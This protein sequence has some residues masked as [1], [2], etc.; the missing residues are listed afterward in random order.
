M[1][2]AYEIPDRGLWLLR[3][4]RLEALLDPLL[5]LLDACPPRDTLAPQAVVAAHPGMRQWLLAA[6]ARRRGP[7]GIVAN[8]DVVLPGAWLDG[9]VCDVLDAPADAAR[10]WRRDLLRWRVHD[11]LARL[12]D[13]RLD[14]GLH[15]PDAA[16]R[17]F[18]LADRLAR[19][20]VQYLVYRPDWLAAW[21]DGRRVREL[22][23]ADA[24][25]APLW[26]A[27]RAAI[28]SPH[29]GEQ[30]ERLLA[31]LARGR[32][33][34][35]D[36][37]LHLFGLT[38]LPPADLEVL[39]ALA[40][41][42]L[43]VLYV[44]DPCASEHWAGMPSERAALRA[45]AQADAG[46]QS[47]ETAFLQASH[48]LLGSFGRIGQH[49]LLLLEDGDV[50]VDERHG[51]DLPEA[52][53]APRDLLGW[54][55]EGIRRAEPALARPAP[56]P[57]GARADRS[58]RVHACHTRLRELEVLR[59]ALLMEL[60]ERPDL[61]PADIVVMAPDIGAYAPLLPAVFGAPGRRHGPLPWHLAD[62]PTA[63]G[64]PLRV[65]FERLLGI[66][67]SRLT[68]PEVA[69]LL[70]LPPIAGR[71]GLSTGD[72]DTLVRWLREARAAW[73]LDAAFRERFGVPTVAAQTF[74]WAM[75]RVLAGYAIGCDDE[76]PVVALCDGAAIAPLPGIAGAQAALAGAL[77]ALLV[78]LATWCEAAQ[79][80]RQASAWADWLDLRCDALLRPDP[81]DPGARDAERALRQAIRRVADEPAA[82]G[83]DPPLAF[84]VVRDLLRAAL[85][86]VPER[87]PFLTGAITACG[88]VA[89]RAVPF[90]VVAV[91][92]L[93]DGALPRAIDDAGLDPVRNHRR[94]G[95]RDVRNDDRWLFLQ[96]LMSARDAL[97]LSFVGEGVRDGRPRN[98]AA[99]LAELFALLDPDP[100]PMPD[101]AGDDPA[102]HAQAIARRPWFVRHPLQPFD[103][104]Y[105][106]GA[107]PALFS[108]R[109]E[110]AALDLRAAPVAAAPATPPRAGPA[111]TSGEAPLREVLA[112][113]RDPAKHYLERQVRLR[114]DALAEDRLRDSEP[115]GDRF[116]A[117]DGVARRLFL[118]ALATPDR[119][120]PVEPPAWL[121][122]TGVLAPGRPGMQAWR[123]AVE[124]VEVLLA[125]HAA[126]PL[127][128]AGRPPRTRIA[129]DLAVGAWR[130][131][132]E[133]VRVHLAG[134]ARWV[135]DA[136]P[137]KS[138]DELDFGKRTALFL[139]WALLRLTDP[140]ASQGARL[141]AACTKGQAWQEAINAWDEAY[142]RDAGA[143]GARREDLARRVQA[144]LARWADAQERPPAYYPR[145]S[146]AATRDAAKID[147]AWWP[148]H[149]IGERDHAPGYARLLAGEAPFGSGDREALIA[150]ARDLQQLVD[151]RGPA[152][153]ATP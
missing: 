105:F 36:T 136:W 88:M 133:A 32:P 146:W 101:P 58:L 33:G 18:G 129:I 118:D 16:R 61:T 91:L 43:V 3:A 75:D 80:V 82:C 98:P 24:L 11:A 150:F 7:G 62:R 44:P 77:D 119:A 130:V 69:D 63:S 46:A 45:L 143:R 148:G 124:Q 19:I 120:L 142:V 97:H 20:L 1:P 108:F 127:F 8:L 9:L 47:T 52:Q 89:Q 112:W 145:T 84:A 21:R 13:P 123:K 68:A 152:A 135:F 128:A 95:D 96:T 141:L 126:H 70:A 92:G 139:E 121:A 72:I 83:L 66:P 104:R 102:R 26:R 60:R 34:G 17:R 99:P 15:G 5:T 122:A 149:G 125:A 79:A 73:G 109:P 48:P 115:L 111:A 40:H 117:L 59:D 114:L 57:G 6:L 90:R 107:D 113:F 2:Q 93:D 85:A 103:V 137:G 76:A 110:F 74:G 35:D 31:R 14:A 144:L 134:G 25:L 51:R 138:E 37:P 147:A 78:E 71:L 39:R 54:L 10:A 12:D 140:D 42:R 87:Q 67:G 81:D 86:E 106:D 64:H 132:G 56:G 49:F 38:H 131:R 41:H 22:D 29:R 28:D 30:L 55:Q 50:A 65:A 23:G 153:G 4:S 53:A 100:A 151:L 116:D 94:I 27:V